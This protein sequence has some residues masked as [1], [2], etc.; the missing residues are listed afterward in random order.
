MIERQITSEVEKYNN[1]ELSDFVE[2]DIDLLHNK[3]V[4]RV[5]RVT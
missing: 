5:S 3:K 2:T 1:V 4:D